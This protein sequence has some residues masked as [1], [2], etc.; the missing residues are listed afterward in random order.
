[1]TISGVSQKPGRYQRSANGLIGAMLVTLLAIGA[2]LLVR[3]LVR[4]DV[5]VEP[6][7]VDYAAAADA[8]RDAGFSVVA[9]AS[10]PTGW[11][12]TSV[13][14]AQT[15]PPLWGMGMLTDDGKFVGVRQEDES[16]RDLAISNVDEDAVE[17]DPL[18][19]PSVVGDTWTTWTDEGGDT[20]YSIEYGDQTVLVYGSAPAEDLQEII[21]R[22]ER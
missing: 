14:F 10:L 6:E 15:D 18:R 5:E 8:A 11:R 13:D 1:M 19:M 12:A 3:S 7:P 20:G 4:P 22:L 21:S 2:F 9:P 17:G 16:E